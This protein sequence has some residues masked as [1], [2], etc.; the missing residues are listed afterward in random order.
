M[1]GRITQ[2]H[3]KNGPAYLDADEPY[4]AA[5]T[6]AIKEIG[7]EGWIVL[8]TSSPSGDGVADAKRNGDF[9]RRLFA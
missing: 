4:F 6:A 7:F 9:V 5:V 8:E 1:K 3:Y 2:F